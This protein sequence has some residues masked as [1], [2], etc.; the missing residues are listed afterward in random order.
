MQK[1]YKVYNRKNHPVSFDPTS[2]P[3]DSMIIP[4]MSQEPLVLEMTEEMAALAE[5]AGLRVELITQ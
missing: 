4:P 5:K 2:D 3:M 1:K